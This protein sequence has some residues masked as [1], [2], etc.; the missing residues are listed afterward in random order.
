MNLYNI[1]CIGKI[2]SFNETN[3]GRYLISFQGIIVLKLIKELKKNYKFR[4]V[5]ANIIK[6]NE[7]NLILLMKKII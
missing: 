4:L 2:H 7:N 6:K 3:D 5:N 1:G